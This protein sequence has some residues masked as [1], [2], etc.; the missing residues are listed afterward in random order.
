MLK[1]MLAVSYAKLLKLMNIVLSN[2]FFQVFL[3]VKSNRWRRL[4]NELPQG[5]VLAP[6]LFNLYLSDVPSNWML[7]LKH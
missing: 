3:G 6:I 4:K 7:A 1:F 2:R 5:S